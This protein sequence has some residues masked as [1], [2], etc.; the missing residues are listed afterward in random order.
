MIDT[1]TKEAII[2]RLE[3]AEEFYIPIKKIWKELRR[4]A[5]ELPSLPEFEEELRK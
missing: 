3:T 1:K 4:E 2:S 5:F